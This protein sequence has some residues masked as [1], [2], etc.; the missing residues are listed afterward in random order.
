MFKIILKL[1]I[2]Q[3]C[4]IGPEII[5]NNRNADNLEHKTKGKDNA[6]EANALP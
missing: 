5:R 6:Q 1:K 4:T 3:N 2:L